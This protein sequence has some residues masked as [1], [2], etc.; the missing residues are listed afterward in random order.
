MSKP[1]DLHVGARVL[2]AFGPAVVVEIG[3]HGPT[4]KDALGENQFA[5]W[6]KIALAGIGDDG[7]DAV[8]LSLQP[9]WNSLEPAIKAEAI[10]RME[11]VFEL[12][13]GFQDGHP[14]M[15]RDGEPFF[16]FGEGFGTSLTQRLN[17]M[18]RQLTFEYGVDRVR[19]RRL[20]AGEVTKNGISAS[21]I[22]VWVKAWQRDGLRGLVDGR[23]TKGRQGFEVIDPKFIRIADEEFARF[24]GDISNSNL[25]EIERRILTRL[26]QEGVDDVTLP[27]RITQQYLSTRFAALGNTTRE[28][29]SA[30][31][32]KNSSRCN[33][34]A[35][36]PGHF[37]VD[38]TRAD[39]LV[40]DDTYER[41]YSV[42]I[43]TII[44]IPTRVVVACRVVPRSANALEVALALYDA[45]RPFSMVVEGET[46][47]DDFR[48][49]GIPAS[50]D[51]GDNPVS[52]H[53]SR[54]RTDRAVVGRHVKPGIAPAS[55]RADNGSIFLS[56]DLRAML[57]EWGVDLMPSRAGRPLDN[58]IVE[59]WH[60]RLQAAYQSFQNGAGF[61]GRAAY[62]R[63]RFVGW[64]GFE[65][66]GSWRELQQ[67][68]H[69][70]IAIDYHRN[71]H[72]GIKVPGLES[73]N[74]T[75]LERYDMLSHSAGRLLVPQ[76][77]DLIFSMLPE[78]WLTPGNGGI[79]FRGLT[80]DGD[81]LEEI[82]GVRPGTYRAKD[83]KVPFLY[84]PRDRSRMWHRSIHNDR[85]HE[86][87][88]RDA[89]LVDAPLTDV[90]VDAARALITDRGGNGVVSR[91]NVARE[92][93][94]AITQLTTGPT[95]EEWRGK[96]I[97]A[98]M[99]HDQAIIDYAEAEAARELVEAQVAAGSPRTGRIP[100]QP[101]PGN[102]QVPD[103]GLRIDFDA[104][105]PDYDQ[106]D[107]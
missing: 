39:N 9:W 67:H 27:Q 41:V 11:V 102:A 62:E 29:K 85:V 55:L 51:F 103:E 35:T 5:R 7:V 40:W 17:A 64:V 16:P 53:E 26:A 63:G 70:F 15:A 12:L 36:H 76:H 8:H 50:L 38:V 10:T 18:S 99:R 86:L 101:D 2:M 30:G 60:D 69:R 45:M 1:L 107:G 4:V 95:D 46:S 22:R 6:D 72:G 14:L 37:A 98:R 48:W 92:I 84:D 34:P 57:L 33:Y 93:I 20:L 73:G 78:K 65:P 87:V 106:Q 104:A 94:A 82:R 42:E 43:I 89:H 24:N 52:A 75:P 80:Y 83:A 47:I 74:F 19:A 44:S 21:A 28:A 90:V 32:R 54:V 58:S 81:I 49:C 31:L 56:K 105:L 100:A 66:L 79:A 23:K 13:T 71:R 91:R 97:R 59:R 61:K 96:L 77:P 25:V 88:W 3:R 68:L